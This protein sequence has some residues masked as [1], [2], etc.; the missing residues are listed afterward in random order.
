[1]KKVFTK[2][3]FFLFLTPLLLLIIF[4]F[5]SAKGVVG[6]YGVNRTIN[7]GGIDIDGILRNPIYTGSFFLFTYPIYLL[8]YFIIFLIGRFTDFLYSIVHFITFILNYILL[9]NNP[10]NRIL[11]P[12]TMIGFIIFILNIFKTTKNPSTINKQPS[13]I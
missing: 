4:Y 8:S 5:L 12:L 1:M 13:T 10:E 2:H 3:L 9:S 11:I 7:F 6:T